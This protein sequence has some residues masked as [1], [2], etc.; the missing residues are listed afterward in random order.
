MVQSHITNSLGHTLSA[1][2]EFA[3]AFAFALAFNFDFDFDFDFTFTF[4][5]EFIDLSSIDSL[6]GHPLEP[7]KARKS[8]RKGT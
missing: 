6:P 5:F 8:K 1:F 4:D 3:F 7:R 2:G